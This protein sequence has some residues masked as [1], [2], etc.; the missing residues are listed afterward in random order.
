MIGKVFADYV[1]APAE[2][3]EARWGE[4]FLARAG[5]RNG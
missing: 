3:T 1:A 5:R 2:H 4:E